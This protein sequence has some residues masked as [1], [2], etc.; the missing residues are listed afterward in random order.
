MWSEMLHVCKSN[1]SNTGVPIFVALVDRNRMIN[2]ATVSSS[3]SRVIALFLLGAGFSSE[4]EMFHVF[5]GTG[6]CQDGADFQ[7]F[8]CLFIPTFARCLL[9]RPVPARMQFTLDQVG[10]VSLELGCSDS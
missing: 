6:L 9:Y 2:V 3:S 1:V 8:H 10:H 4:V 7:V 5:V